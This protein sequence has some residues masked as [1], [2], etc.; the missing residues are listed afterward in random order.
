MA[1][2]RM[3]ENYRDERYLAACETIM[4]WLEE[5]YAEDGG[6]F[7]I[8]YSPPGKAKV[9]T[10]LSDGI[11]SCALMRHCEVTG[12]ERSWGMLKR[13]VDDDLDKTGLIRPEGFSLKSTSPFRDYYEPE[14]DFWFEA[15]V[16]MTQKTGD[17]R[18]EDVG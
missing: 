11:L 15:L 16:Y 13:L 2:S 17:E 6:Y 4:D 8:G 1:L 9:A 10:S 14:P 18:Y 3:Y 5:W 12:S 7:Y